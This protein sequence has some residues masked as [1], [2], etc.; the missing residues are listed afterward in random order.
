MSSLGD[1]CDLIGRVELEIIFNNIWV[2]GV[3]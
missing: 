1:C 3:K 2:G